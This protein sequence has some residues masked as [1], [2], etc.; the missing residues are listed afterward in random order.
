MAEVCG[1]SGEGED[2]EDGEKRRDGGSALSGEDVADVQFFVDFL[3]PEFR[4][5]VR[6]THGVVFE[7]QFP[8]QF[9]VDD[10]HFVRGKVSEVREVV[11]G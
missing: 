3:E 11:V 10:L 7:V 4:L 6:I 2:V 9:A 8:V 1:E 5:G